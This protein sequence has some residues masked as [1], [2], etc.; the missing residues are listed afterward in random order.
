[1]KSSNV[2]LIFLVACIIQYI[3]L[4]TSF[5]QS[6]DYY[7]TVARIGITSVLMGVSVYFHIT[8]KSIGD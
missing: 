8:R 6:T 4:V 2:Y 5:V 3:T 1:M 7:T